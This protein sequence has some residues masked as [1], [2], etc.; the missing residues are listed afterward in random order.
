MIKLL[1]LHTISEILIKTLFNKLSD[2]WDRPTHLFDSIHIEKKMRDIDN[3]IYYFKRRKDL[4]RGPRRTDF[5]SI[6]RYDEMINELENTK[7]FYRYVKFSE[8]YKK[9]P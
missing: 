7:K 1:M 2:N 4:C 3:D 5:K 8:L 6:N 9:A